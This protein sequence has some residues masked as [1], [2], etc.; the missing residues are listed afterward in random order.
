MCPIPSCKRYSPRASATPVFSDLAIAQIDAAL[1][2]PPLRDV[3]SPSTTTRTRSPNHRV[4][5]GA[6]RS[7]LL[8]SGVTYYPPS[9]V[10][11]PAYTPDPPATPAAADLLLGPASASGVGSPLM[12]ISVV[13]VIQLVNREL[14]KFDETHVTTTRLANVELTD[15][16]DMEVD[17]PAL[18]S[19]SSSRPQRP[20][21]RGR[22]SQS[23]QVVSGRHGD[24][25]RGGQA[26]FQIA[27]DSGS[28]SQQLGNSA[29]ADA[30]GLIDETPS[31]SI[32][33]ASSSGSLNRAPSK[34]QKNTYD[35]DSSSRR[36]DDRGAAHPVSSSDPTST[37]TLAENNYG[38]SGFEKE[39]MGVLECDVCAMLLHE[40]VTTPCQHVS[41]CSHLSS[42]LF[43]LDIF[44]HSQR[45]WSF[46]CSAVP[47]APHLL[48][49]NTIVAL[50]N[51]CI[52]AAT[53]F[54]CFSCIARIV[55]AL[56]RDDSS[57]RSKT[58]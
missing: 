36:R 45:S 7:E 22:R 5:S 58:R 48:A 27:S 6:H 50:F 24:S 17:Q 33:E 53:P 44:S 52:Q 9:P 40:P 49:S 32:S 8:A 35:P 19:S 41:W 28:L 39:L 2:S 16:E 37:T 34:R 42:W 11:P 55:K 14:A 13:K 43:F 1:E 51:T 30:A 15:E 3:T 29:A 46:T 23:G 31:P 38:R 56:C 57:T 20:S 18:R 12:D 10:A 4:S 21:L 26:E 25:S 54:S 47:C